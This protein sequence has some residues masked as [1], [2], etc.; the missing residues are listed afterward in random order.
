MKYGKRPHLSARDIQLL[1]IIGLVVVAVMGTLIGAD[2]RLSQ[3]LQGGGGFFGPWEAA[4]AFLFKNTDPYSGTV[5]R[6]AQ[7]D[8]YGRAAR[9]G[10]NRYFLQMPFL[11]LP[12]YFPFALIADPAVARGFWLFVSE[13]AL[14]TTALLM[15]RLTEWQP[16]RWFQIA[17]TLATVFSLYSVMSLLEAGPAI[18]LG[19]VY[20]ASL[21]AYYTEQDELTGALLVLS[22]FAWEVGLFFV[23]L[24]LW[25][26]ANER[27]WRVWM[28]AGMA[29]FVLG[30]ISFILY[31]KWLFPF[32]MATVAT[33][34]SPFG[35]NSGAILERISPAYGEHAAQALTVLL[36]LLLLYEWAATRRHDV[37]RFIWAACLTLAVTPLIGLRM[38]LGNLVVILPGLALVFAGIINRWRSGYWLAGLVLL[39]AF[40]LPWGWFVRWYWLRD[41]LAHDLLLL[42][43]PA[44]TALG[45]YWT[46]WWFVRPPLT[47]LD[48]VH[49]TLSHTQPKANAPRYPGTTG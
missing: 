36:I 6:L 32:V 12:A 30:F 23:L 3:G 9:P 25:K 26:S 34:R 38:E 21:Y 35:T 18:L 47:W 7:E 41:G 11:L 37:R 8:A 45:L 13:V 14:A 29:L 31:P 1:F 24:L 40:L 42:F 43:L 39:I 28:G 10:E 44:F 48:H 15:L 4:R 46:R 33:I 19:L 2:I 5:A 17:F 20:C 49:S 16:A 27:R 22:L